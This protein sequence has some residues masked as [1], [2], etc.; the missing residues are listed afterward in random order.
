MKN[1]IKLSHYSAFGLL[2]CP[3]MN[4]LEIA[5]VKTGKGLA[6]S[7]VALIFA[8]PEATPGS[9]TG[10][11]RFLNEQPHLRAVPGYHGPNQ[12]HVLRVSGL[13]DDTHFLD[14]L[15]REYPLWQ[16]QHSEFPAAAI[17]ANID[18]EKLSEVDHFP[19]QSLMRRFVKENANALTGSAYMV[20]NMA[21]LYSAFIAPKHMP[22]QPRH[23]WFK[24]YSALA[25]NVAT[26]SLLAFGGH[27]DRP[28]DVYSIMEE[29]Y[30]N[31]TTIDDHSKEKVQSLVEKTGVF[32]RNH[33][34]EINAAINATGA[35]AHLTSALL[36][37][38][39]E[40]PHAT[41][42]ALSAFGTLTAMAITAFMPEKDGRDLFGVSDMFNRSEKDSITATT[43]YVQQIE[44][45][46]GET[47][48]RIQRFGQ[49]LKE[50]PLALAAGVQSISN[51]GYGAAGLARGD[52]GLTTM[53]AAYLTGNALQTQAT[54][55]RGPGFDDVVTAAATVIHSDPLLANK[56]PE[57]RNR[58]IHQFAAALADEKE[59]VHK[60]HRIEQAIHERLNRYKLPR[61]EENQIL[62]GFV[63]SEEKILKKS[64]F[65]KPR[66]VEKVLG[67]QHVSSSIISA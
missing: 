56:T 32:M 51:A 26:V 16:A 19:H 25:Y 23:D 40:A 4:S 28:R 47:K 42:E 43:D 41:Y 22:G 57:E 6:D 39:A 14:L 65:V 48:N 61:E 38:G 2:Y 7:R 13:K 50:N 24:A 52:A 29:L 54:K 10:L 31:L 17:A 35:I 63:A 34:W 60:S 18:C 3:L 53:S 1:V 15:Q 44:P 67:E 33:P 20:G 8:P 62:T 11:T 9:L 21:L 37:R 5:K 49:W 45:E 58:H 66:Y 46:K 55:G 12:N 36:R 27:S 59:V 30:P 64:P